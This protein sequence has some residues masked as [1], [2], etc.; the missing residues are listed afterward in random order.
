MT[1]RQMFGAGAAALCFLLSGAA[2]A[3]AGAAPA[4][5]GRIE[6][7]LGDV[8]LNKVPWLVAADQGI[9]AKH[10]LNVHQYINAYAADKARRQGV[11]VP[12]EFVRLEET[13][14][15]HITVGGGTP[16]I[17][18]Y[19]RD[20]LAADRVIIA[21]FEG[22]VRSHIVSSAAI[23]TPADLKGKKLGYSGDDSVTHLAALAWAQHMGWDPRRDISLF[24][25]GNT[26]D[27]IVSGR[28]DAFIGSALVQ[29]L[30]A[31]QNLKDLLDLTPLQIPVAGSGLNA[32]RT[33]LRNNRD[34][35]MRFVMASVEAVARVKRDKKAFTDA[36]VKWFNI[37][38]AATQ[39]RMYADV[40][41]IPR[42]PQPAV[43]GIRKTME[44]FNY[45]EMNRHKPEDFYDASFVT[46]LE[47]NGFIASLYR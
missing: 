27:A 24:I 4:A 1:I 13:D 17:V 35:A 16:M 42:A 36:M 34:T 21:T 3:L 29:S 40:A 9:Y 18:S 11:D 43:A 32:E 20:V 5:Q 14:D 8:S 31:K 26:P 7:S 47:R 39:D 38:D 15:A 6:V 12:D 46:E 2:V 28:I 19:T 37:R 33:W 30:A 23:R 10:G 25:N 45:H 22:V 41:G 44:L